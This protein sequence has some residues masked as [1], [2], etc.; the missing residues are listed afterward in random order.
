MAQ[1]APSSIVASFTTEQ[2]KITAEMRELDLLIESTQTE[3]NRLKQREDTVKTKLDG[4]RANQT[5]PEAIA[6]GDEF[7]S[8]QGRRLTMEG[9][10]GSLQAKRKL[11]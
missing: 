2:A 10:M 8:A 5:N 9:Q 11:L 1:K 3:V 6:A 4:I 7:A